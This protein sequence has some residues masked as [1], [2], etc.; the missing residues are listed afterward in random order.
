MSNTSERTPSP[1][2]SY[3]DTINT[4]DGSVRYAGFEPEGGP[5]GDDVM[6]LPGTPV[7]DWSNR[8]LGKSLSD[9]SE[10]G[11]HRSFVV[12]HNAAGI[13]MTESRIRE[14]YP[15]AP[16]AVFSLGVD[17]LRRAHEAIVVMDIYK[18][19]T[20]LVAHSFGGMVSV[21]I[22][23]LRPDLVKSITLLNS[24]G[25]VPKRKVSEHEKIFT[26]DL[27]KQDPRLIVSMLWTY[28]MNRNRKRE[29]KSIAEASIVQMLAQIGRSGVPVTIV[30]DK[31]DSVFPPHE[32]EEELKKAGDPP[33]FAVERTEGSK[34]NGPIVNP[35]VY[36]KIVSRILAR[37]DAVTA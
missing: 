22:A 3:E 24:A 12:N 29:T 18:A 37:I 27:F 34:H 5:T 4:E 25:L 19:K 7:S 21:A 6:L 2:H 36:G 30:Y 1:A 17:A 13:H 9:G 33:P 28:F 10:A 16:E 15:T 26:R 20:H 32:I 11:S 31:A 8:R 14:I 35:G 23:F